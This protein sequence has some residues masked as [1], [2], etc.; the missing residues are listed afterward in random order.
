VFKGREW[1]GEDLSLA[2]QYTQLTTLELWNGVGTGFRYHMS[3]DDTFRDFVMTQMQEARR[4]K[5]SLRK[6]SV[7][8][9]IKN[10]SV[11]GIEIVEELVEY[12]ASDIVGLIGEI[13]L[14]DFATNPSME[15]IFPKWR[16]GGTSKSRGID[17]VA[18]MKMN[19]QWVLI[20]CEAKHI[21]KAAKNSRQEL[22]HNLIKSRFRIGL[23]EFENEKTKINLLNI[24]M[25]LNDI[26]ARGE[27][28][29][30]DVELAKEYRN[31]ISMGLANDRYQI[32]VVVLIDAKYC[33]E[34]LLDRSI[35]ELPIPVE[36]GGNRQIT[37]TLLESHLIEK[38]TDGVCH[39]FVGSP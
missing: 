35:S 4:I 27:A 25:G 34:T 16:I 33:D 7:R 1:K 39:N 5:T 24:V 9:V 21:H 28:V 30:L 22:R 10:L 17:L 23:D 31:L 14:E 8:E 2:R 29:K 6:R 26:I 3:C 13:V 36:V 12:D 38:A 18:R 11:R 32:N 15:P 20:L 19:G 37:L